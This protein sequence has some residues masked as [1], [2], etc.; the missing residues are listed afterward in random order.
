MS[1]SSQASAAVRA[2]AG[3]DGAALRRGR[4]VGVELAV[5]RRPGTDTFTIVRIYLWPNN[6]V[7]DRYTHQIILC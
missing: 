4:L 7:S 1:V 2:D 3:P 6:A 5:V